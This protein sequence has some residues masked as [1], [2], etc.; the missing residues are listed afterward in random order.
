MSCS[1][2]LYSRMFCP[3]IHYR[4]YHTHD[5]QSYPSLYPPGH[6]LL[7]VK[8]YVVLISENESVHISVLFD[9]LRPHGLNPLFMEFSRQEYWSGLPCPFPGDLPDPGIKSG[10]PALQADCLPS[11]PPGRPI[12]LSSPNTKPEI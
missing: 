4:F 9:S 8:R 1:C 2:F 6:Q 10:S 7:K 3:C 11:E 12:Y 5:I